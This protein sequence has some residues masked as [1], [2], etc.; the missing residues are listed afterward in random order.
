MLGAKII[1][2]N[3]TI[4]IITDNNTKQGL[5]TFIIPLFVN[6]SRQ[7]VFL[8]PV[9]ITKAITHKQQILTNNNRYCIR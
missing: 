1:K 3:R 5:M 8:H 4:N 2:I 6:N 9:L 7:E